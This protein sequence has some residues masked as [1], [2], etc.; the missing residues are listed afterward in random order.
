M[1]RGRAGVCAAAAMG[2]ALASGCGQDPPSQPWPGDPAFY[3]HLK[4][5]KSDHGRVAQWAHQF[6]SGGDALAIAQASGFNCDQN[7]GQPVWTY[8]CIYTRRDASAGQRIEL[9]TERGVLRGASAR[10]RG[11]P[12]IEFA[13]AQ[14]FAAL[15]ADQ[16]R[17]AGP[18]PRVRRD[19]PAWDGK[20]FSVHSYGEVMDKLRQLGFSCEVTGTS[21]E[22]ASVRCDNRSFSG[23]KQELVLAVS[24]SDTVLRRMEGRVGDASVAVELIGRPDRRDGDI[25]LLVR[26]ETAGWRLMRLAWPRRGQPFDDKLAASFAGLTPASRQRVLRALRQQLDEQFGQ[27]SDAVFS[28]LLSHLDYGSLQLRRLGDAALQQAYEIAAG[29]HPSTYASFALAECD[30][31]AAAEAR[32]CLA[33][34][35]ARRPELGDVLRKAIAEAEPSVGALPPAHP[36]VLRITRLR[37]ALEPSDRERRSGSRSTAPASP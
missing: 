17:T 30:R 14:S 36:A 26:D 19:V 13:D 1:I 21:G 37:A 6:M 25:G 12:G 22:Q 27:D 31:K 35:A 18:L 29:S 24:L 32:S 7:P 34:Y 4:A 2:L 28:P 11:V 10:V 33:G 3:A 9:L 5:N 23:Q 20:P 15:I 16:L 8:K